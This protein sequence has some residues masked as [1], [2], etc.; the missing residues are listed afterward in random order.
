MTQQEYYRQI[1]IIEQQIEL[2]K[3]LKCPL[4]AKK[5]ERQLRDFIKHYGNQFSK[6]DGND[7]Q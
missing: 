4:M 3:K 5:Y 6:S 1:D 7:G 2:M